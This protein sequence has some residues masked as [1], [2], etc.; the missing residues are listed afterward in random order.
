MVAVMS[1]HKLLGG[2]GYRYLTRQVAAGDARLAASDPLVAYYDATATPPGRWLGSG[3]WAF[4]EG[5]DRLR[6]GSLVSDAAMVAVFRDGHDPL[7]HRPL[8][9]EFGPDSVRGFDMSF[10]PF[11]SAQ[12]LW[13]LAPAE[14]RV[15]VQAAHHAAVAQALEVV[16]RSAV[17]TRTGAGGRRQVSTRGMIAAAFDHFDTRAGDPGLHTHVVLA[18]K[19]QGPDRKWR[20]LDGKTIHAA[21]VAVSELYDGLLADELHRRLGVTC[22]YRSRGDGRNEA[23]E[24]DGIDDTLIRE[25]SS[26]SDRIHQAELAWAEDFTAKRGRGPSRV[27]TIKARQHLTR[28]TRPAKTIRPLS[29][30]LAEWANRARALTGLEPHDLAA[31]AL[32]GEYGRG[33]HAHDVGPLTREALV[34]QT[35]DDAAE[36]RSVWTTWNLRAAAARTT[37]PLRMHDPAQRTR[38]IDQIVTT[39]QAQCVHLDAQRDPATRRAGEALFTSVDLLA[40]ERALLEAA[41]RPIRQRPP[42][43]LGHALTHTPALDALAPDQ[44]EAVEALVW[45]RQGLDVLVGPAG[46][47]KTTTLAALAQVWTH[48]GGRVIGLAPSASAAHTLQE[49]LKV[50]CHTTAKW[51]YETIGEGAA[52]RA[53]DFATGARTE[54]RIRA[55]VAAD[56]TTPFDES[57]FDEAV[58]SWQSAVI[59]QEDWRLQPGHLVIVDEA[60]LADTRTL[61][62]LAAQ[63]QAGDARILLVGDHLQRGSVGAGG[64]FGMLARRSHTAELTSLWR[65]THPWEARASLALRHA[66]PEALDTYQAHGA[67]SAGPREDMLDAALTHYADATDTG[68]VV[69]LQAADTR[70][71]RDL[72]AAA[73]AHAILTGHARPDG[74]V[75][76]HDGL[77]ATVGDR[78]VT[79]RN[80]RRLRT[81]DGHVRNGTLWHITATHRDGSI[82]V[83]PLDDGHHRGDDGSRR[84]DDGTVHL[85][86]GYVAEHVELGYAVTTARSQG[87]TV[88]QTHTIAAIGMAR[89]D[90][91]VAMTRGRHTNRLYVATDLFDDDCPTPAGHHERT[92]T[93]RDVLD[94]ILA[95]SHADLSATETWAQYQPARPVPIPSIAQIQAR[96]TRTA[97]PVYRSPVHTLAAPTRAIERS[98]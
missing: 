98:M 9:R 53:I 21:T 83:R 34:A 8:G 36:H 94:R 90:L 93:G 44:R 32:S 67:I 64:A 88:D 76:L 31:R 25:F 86:A 47:G 37:I 17:R 15:E 39:A 23:F 35:L 12:V 92:Q 81:D 85:P 87:L 45:S 18:N 20:S 71:V 55:A 89:E 48:A 97:E 70:T 43:I 57:K 75:Q 72:N 41:E 63:A 62:E 24:I 27:E 69:L 59:S 10:S 91:Y 42:L 46:T 29:E 96:N 51:L 95:T 28:Q 74:G 16:S 26:R 79:R 65:F 5:R 52:R 80:D 33:L 82:G 7:T 56:P 50:P 66:Q 2:D 4:G 84:P 68:N 22:S 11:K 78:I 77:V 61:A 73:H 58:R 19:V 60:S 40:A 1:M 6:P 49:A 54:Q 38:L 14:V 3:L 30:L 13:G